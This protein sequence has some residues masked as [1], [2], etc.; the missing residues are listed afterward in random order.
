MN[1]IEYTEHL[2][3][4]QENEILEVYLDSKGVPTAGVGHAFHAGSKI[5]Q[6]ISDKLFEMDLH[7]A[8]FDCLKF[9]FKFNMDLDGPREA[10]II[11]MLFNMGY[12]KTCKF[13]RM[14]SAI[15]YK[16][17]SLAAFEMLDSQYANDV[18]DRAD[19]L[20]EIMETGEMKC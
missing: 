15:K 8:Y 18:K 20:A 2:I 1:N 16:L 10:V 7:I 17:Y 19:E 3:K 4:K 11:N 9:K 5:T 13:K 14:I 12:G 6:E